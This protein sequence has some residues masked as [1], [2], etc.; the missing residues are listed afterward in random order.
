MRI[1]KH[2]FFA[3]GKKPAFS[4]NF[5]GN[6]EKDRTQRTKSTKTAKK[7]VLSLVFVNPRFFICM[8]LKKSI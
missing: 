8:E 6:V 5:L 7:P 4:S 2:G 3:F 1:E